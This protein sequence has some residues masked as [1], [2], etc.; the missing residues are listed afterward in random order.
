MH[1]TY[2]A[3]SAHVNPKS[4]GV[5]R[6]WRAV[7]L[8]FVPGDQVIVVDGDLRNLEG[9]VGRRSFTPA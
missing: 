1:P 8:Q 7:D 3:K 2:P 9:V 5:F 6:P 4:G